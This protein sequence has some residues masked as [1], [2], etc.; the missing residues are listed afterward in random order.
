MP[1]VTVEPLLP[2][3]GNE[4]DEEWDCQTCIHEVR[5]DD[6]LAGGIFLPGRWNQGDFAYDG[7]LVE[8]E[9]DGTKE[10]YRLFGRIRL[11]IRLSVDSKC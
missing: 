10:G 11:E 5:G 4:G 6:G 8:G 7:R 2:Q 9:E 3:H 1:Q